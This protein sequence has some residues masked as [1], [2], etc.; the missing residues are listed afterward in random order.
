MYVLPV[1]TREKCNVLRKKSTS[2]GDDLPLVSPFLLARANYTSSRQLENRAAETRLLEASAWRLVNRSYGYLI[3]SVIKLGP[4]GR[5]K[6]YYGENVF[7]AWKI[8]AFREFVLARLGD[9]FSDV[10]FR[11]KLGKKILRLDIFTVC[12]Q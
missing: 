8:A 3:R 1:S 7:S 4:Q 2:R 10:N 6:R 11:V 9:N 5:Q 12:V